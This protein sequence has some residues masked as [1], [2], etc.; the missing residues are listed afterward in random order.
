MGKIIAIDGP[1]GVGKSTISKLLSKELGYMY[2]D[3]GAMYRTVA[4]LA[5]EVGLDLTDGIKVAELCRSLSFSFHIEGDTVHV[6][7]NERDVTEEIRTHEMGMHASIVSKHPSVREVL[8]SLQ[9][10]LGKQ[11]DAILEGRDI[12]T[13]VFPH[14]TFKFY[15]DASVD[16]RARRRYRELIQKGEK[17]SFQEVRETMKLRDLNDSTRAIAPLRP[18]KDAILI[19]TTRMDIPAVISEILWH[20]KGKKTKKWK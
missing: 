20:V 11:H 4:L 6:L 15:L 13:V 10:G 19:D 1:S 7:C 16:E 3:T 12:G 17:V 14:A 18:A 8:V 2:I 9:R 5:I